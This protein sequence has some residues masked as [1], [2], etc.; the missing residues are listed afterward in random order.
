MKILLLY[1]SAGG[2]HKRAAQALEAYLN[3]HLE[4]AEVRV[5][6]ALKYAGK[7]V[8]SICCDGYRFSAK[9]AP[10]V[11]G[12]LYRNTNKPTR[13][14]TL[15]PRINALLSKKLLALL[16]EFQPDIVLDTYHFAGQM[17]STLKEKGLTKVP[18]VNILTDYGPHM[19]WLAPHA[20]A[21]VVASDEMADQFAQMG[22]PREKIHPFGI[23]VFE[24]FF[25]QDDKDA[26]LRQMNLV[27]GVPTV[28]IMAGSFGVNHILEVFRDIVMLGADF[29]MIVITGKNEKLYKAF[30][31]EIAINSKRTEL[32]AFTSEV[33]KYMHAADLLITKPGGLTVSEAL[34]SGLPMAVFDAIPGQ[35]EDNADFLQRHNMGVRLKSGASCTFAIRSLLL[36]PRRLEEMRDACRA[37]DKS[38]GNQKILSLILEL[39]GGKKE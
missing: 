7:L 25:A 22:A 4:G 28:L 5:E 31:K 1:A 11:F 30:Q 17:I 32:V 29:Q 18:L 34:A 37:F 14:A 21:Y 6:D 27:P 33:H 36:D 15:L 24:E 8:D 9:H 19:A 35:E 38:D 13:L 3:T 16:E 12:T 23:P 20:D 26:L 39:T 2:G 10:G